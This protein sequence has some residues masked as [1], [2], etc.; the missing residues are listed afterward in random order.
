MAMLNSERIAE[1]REL[2]DPEAAKRQLPKAELEA[3]EAA[4]RSVVE[5]RRAAE[6]EGHRIYIA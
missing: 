2:A 6:A 5:A 3:Y 1:L 4:Q